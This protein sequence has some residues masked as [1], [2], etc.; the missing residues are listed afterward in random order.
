MKSNECK[1][2]DHFKICDFT[3]VKS[4]HLALKVIM[5]NKDLINSARF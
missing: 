3:V 4:K 5:R 1:V 2:I